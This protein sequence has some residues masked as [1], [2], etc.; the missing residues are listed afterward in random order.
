MNPAKDEN[1]SNASSDC[2]SCVVGTGFCAGFGVGSAAGFA[3]SF[4]GFGIVF[5]CTS[6]AVE[7]KIGEID[8]QTFFE[9]LSVFDT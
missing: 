9:R 7:N 6:F 2:D 1:K 5:C 4:F 3:D 8:F